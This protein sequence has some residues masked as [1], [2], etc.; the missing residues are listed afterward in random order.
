MA[1]VFVPSVEFW[2]RFFCQAWSFGVD[3]FVK[4]GVSV[5][6]LSFSLAANFAVVFGPRVDARRVSERR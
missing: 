4:R 1:V 2:G 3:F 6:N 5:S